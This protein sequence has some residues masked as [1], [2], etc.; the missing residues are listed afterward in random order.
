MDRSPDRFAKAA[1]EHTEIYFLFFLPP[2]KNRSKNIVDRG[3]GKRDK[4][5]EEKQDKK[6][7]LFK[8][9]QIF[10]KKCSKGPPDVTDYAFNVKTN[11]CMKAL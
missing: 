9:K 5:C 11:P 10:F 2:Q 6:Y 7:N 1:M 3:D 8:W 4:M